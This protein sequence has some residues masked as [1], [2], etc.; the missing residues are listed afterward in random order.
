MKTLRFLA[1]ESFVSSGPSVQEINSLSHNLYPLVFKAAYVQEEAVLLHD[2]VQTWP[3]PQLNLKRLLGPTA[4][5]QL[6][7]TSRTCRICLVAV[8]TG[9]RDYVLSPQTTYAK[10]LRLFDMTGLQDLERQLCKCRKTLGRWARTEVL[11]RMCYEVMVAMQAGTAALSAFDEQVD[12]HLDAF[13]TGRSYEVVLRALLLRHHC[14]LKMHCVT[15]RADS[16]SVKNLVYF[17]RLAEPEGLQKLEVVHNVHLE[18]VHLEVI[19]SHLDFKE[20]RS[21]TLPARAL[22]VRR[23]GADDTETLGVLGDLLSKLTHLRELC[24]DFSTLT[25]H[26]RKL[27][28]PLN[29]PLQSLELA[30][31]ALTAVDMAYLANSLHSEHLVRLDL[32]GHEVADLFPNTF[33][34]LLQRCSGTLSS[35]SLEEC[36]LE[37]EH[38]E[39]FLVALAPCNGLQELKILGNPLSL[40]SLRRIFNMLARGFPA[41]RYV[42][43][44][45][46]RDCYPEN[47]TY[48]LDDSTL[49]RYDREKFAEARAELVGILE[50][51]GKGHVEVCT[52]LFGAYD[53]DINETSNE[54]GVFMVNSFR[55]VVGTFM[56]AIDEV[57]ERR[58][59]RR[60]EGNAEG[61]EDDESDNV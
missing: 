10:S 15:L 59:R 14:P 47:V 52:P 58:E 48:P 54:L 19:L 49:A 45:V 28:S 25:A 29:T 17:L 6:D 1:A 30:N 56:D 35:L 32:S 36:G 41:L 4:D 7:L 24:L 5:C 44:P 9:L 50:Q 18:A 38:L 42:E 40:A 33:R 34:K 61:T 51:A 23:L 53:P 57:G 37:D 8:F 43:L 26:L 2:L 21:L 60:A 39:M 16:L 27:L 3:L 20:L 13:V 46:P 12:V 55:D 11:T 31:C 22:D